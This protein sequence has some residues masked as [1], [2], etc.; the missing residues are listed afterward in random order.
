MDNLP[1]VLPKREIRME[2]MFF[3]GRQMC[4]FFGPSS[5]VDWYGWL[6]HQPLEFGQKRIPSERP[7]AMTDLGHEFCGHGAT[8]RG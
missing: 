8:D 1:P 7:W 2:A 3:P 5:Y 6:L 4:G